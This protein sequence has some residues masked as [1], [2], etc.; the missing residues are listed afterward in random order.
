MA[1]TWWAEREERR[2]PPLRPGRHQQPRAPSAR[3]VEVEHV[4]PWRPEGLDLGP[5]ASR[6]AELE[7]PPILE[8]ATGL[9]GLAELTAARVLPMHP[10]RADGTG[11]VGLEGSVADV[12][13]RAPRSRPRRP[14]AE[15]PH[16]DRRREEPAASD[17]VPLSKR[18]A[19]LLQPPPEVLLA[20]DGPLE[21]PHE[22]FEY[23]RDGVSALVERDVLLLADDMGLGKTIQTIAALRL[24]AHLR[25]LESAL[26]VLPASLVLQWRRAVREWAPE[27]AVIVIRGTPEERALQWRAQAHIFLVSYETLRQDFTENPRSPPRRRVWD[28][29]VLDEAQRIKNPEAETSRECKRLQRRRAWALT[30]TPLENRIEDLASICEFLTPWTEGDPLLRLRPGPEL[31][32]RHSELQLRRKKGDVLA[33]LPAKT[34]VEVAL[35]LAPSQRL[36][37]ERAEREGVLHL[38]S[39]GETIRITHVLQLIQRLKQITNVC[40]TTGESSKLDDIEL[41]LETLAAEGHRALVFSQYRNETYGAEAAA[42]R[43][44]R[45]RPLVY[46]GELSTDERDRVIEAF[47]RNPEHAA[48][49][50]SLQA[51]GQ[52][53]NLQEASYVFHFDRWWNPAVERQAED[54][55]HRLGQTFP[56]TVYKYVC[57]DTIEERIDAI[58]RRKQALFEELIDDVTLDLERSLSSEELFGLFGLEPPAGERSEPRGH[59]TP[60]GRMGGEE[61]ERWVTDV[62]RNVGLEVEPTP[63]TRDG[64]VDLIAQRTDLSGIVLELWI[65]CKNQRTPVGVEVVREL[66]GVLPAGVRGVVASTSGFT[67]DAT[68]FA[69]E[70]NI[71]LWDADHLQRLA[72]QSSGRSRPA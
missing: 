59:K 71:D 62:L 23:Q 6:P 52:G 55:S 27:L 31:L 25:R 28:A 37:Y 1:T 42:R 56:V 8:T 60:F 65:Q 12:E 66:Q 13:P 58:L 14:A 22:L 16:G 21:W 24:L 38:E 40:P 15:T 11:T 70:R 47:K 43:L 61:F 36:T 29:V 49:V 18:L 51:G 35:Q 69:R 50:L 2:R 32:E 9:S 10:D 20:A 26:L 34:V 17:D 41:R 67:L 33:D 54:R 53:L 4:R 46:T 3:L 30:G 7:V 5:R 19:Y 48:L 39:L 72:E 68:R 45:F 44:E 64:G 63:P 57:E